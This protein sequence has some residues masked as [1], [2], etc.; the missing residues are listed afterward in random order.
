LRKVADAIAQFAAAEKI[1][2]IVGVREFPAAYQLGP[3]PR[4]TAMASAPGQPGY[5]LLR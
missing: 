1:E 5:Q 3:T 4:N 2:A